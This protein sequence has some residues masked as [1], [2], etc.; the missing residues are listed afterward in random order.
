[1][2]ALTGYR[3]QRAVV[4]GGSIGGL[5]AALLLRDLGFDVEVYE[6]ATQALTSRGGGIV[7]QPETL[8]WF[9]ERSARR[10]EEVSTS[11]E[12]MRCLGPDNGVVYEE[13]ITWRYSSWSTIQQALLGDFGTQNYHLGQSMCGLEQDGSSV[14]V[15]FAS[16][17]RTSADLVLCADGISSTARRRLTQSRL[18]YSGY[19][20]WRGTVLESEVSTETF[21]LL[22]D[23]LTYCVADHTHI[24]SYPIPG[25]DSD[26]RIGQRWLN[27]VW[28]RNVP[29]GAQLDELM[30]DRRG[31]PCS[32][33][34]QAGQ[35]QDR[36]IGKLREEAAEIL[37]PAAAELVARTRDPYIQQV[38]DVRVPN[39]AFGRIAL[40]GDA[41]FAARPHAAAGTAKAAADAWALASALENADGDVP[42]ALTK[43]EPAQ[44]RLGHALIDRV[45]EMGT[46]SQVSQTWAPDDPSLRFGLPGPSGA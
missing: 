1:M 37:P 42:T 11:S 32:V 30:T 41:A 4:I 25:P 10:P 29:E 28:Y 24:V 46:R 36:F 44:L 3:A 38:V 27:Y 2:A 13:S 12:V 15:R 43:W 9:T 22:H 16:G 6:R 33:S 5:T 19:V 14:E 45:T 31:T 23:S 7:L 21:R 26:A 35:V 39:M 18:T 8:R 20:G 17:H 40:I 34:V